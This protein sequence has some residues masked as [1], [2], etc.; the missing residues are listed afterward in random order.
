MAKIGEPEIKTQKRVIDLFKKEL[1]YIY[2]GDLSD[3]I[4]TNVKKDK[5]IA[6]LSSE[7]GGKYSERFANNVVDRLL[8]TTNNLQQGLYKANHDVYSILRYGLKIA[9]NI[10]ESI[11]TVYLIDW[12][13]AQNNEFG[14]AE[15]VTIKE[16]EKKRR[17]DLVFYINGIAIAVLELKK[18]TI[19]VSYGIR[20]NLSNQDESF[21]KPFFT[22][23]QLILAGNNSEGLRYGVIETIEKNYLEWKNEDFFIVS[24]PLD[25][26]SLDILEKCKTLRNKLDWQLYS[27]FYKNRLLDLIHNFIIFD[28]GRKKICRY[29]QFFAIK[30]AQMKLNKKEG[31]IIW[32]T[33][34]SGKTMVMVWLSKW[35]LE[36]NSNARVLIVTDREELDSQVESVY[37][38]VEENIYRTKSCSDLIDKL[39]K[40]DK[41]LMCTLIHKF[42]LRSNVESDENYIMRTIKNFIEELE[43]ALPTNFKA[44]GDF[45]VF[46]DECHRTQ[47]GLLHE[48]MKKIL[49]N[50]I[51]I[52]FTGT[53]LMKKDKKTSLEV[54]S[55]GFIH[56]YKYDKAVEDGVV[57]ELKYEAR[58]IDQIIT[59]PEKIEVYFEKKTSGLNDI[60]KA[61]L[62]SKWA[63][64]QTLFSSRN[65]LEILVDDI[66]YDFDTKD[67]LMTDRGNAI[68]VA[69]SIYTACRFYKIFQDRNFKKCAL[70][71]SF[72]S[73]VRTE[74][75]ESVEFEMINIYESMLKDTNKEVFE[76]E[77][78]RKFI[79]EPAQMKLLIVVDKLL[80]GFDAPPCTY[81]YIDKK[82]KD[83]GLFQ[84]ICRV[85]RLD[86]EK[87]FGYIVDYKLSFENLNEALITYTSEA[88]AEYDVEDIKGMIKDR[89]SEGK[90]HLDSILKDLEDLCSGVDHPYEDI[91]YERYF[92]GKDGVGGIDDENC[93]RIRE[94]FYRL[95]NRLIIA[96]SEIKNE[97]TEAGYTE[98]EKKNVEERASFFSELKIEIRN[99]SGDFIDLKGYES[100]M[101]RLIDSYI[102]S[103]DSKQIA[104][105]EDFTLLKFIEKKSEAL[106][107]ESK[108]TAAEIIERN[109]SSR[110]TEKMLINP[111]YYEKMSTLLDELVKERRKG[112]LT[113]QELIEKYRKTCEN[114]ENPE[115]DPRYPDSIRK[116]E[117]LR[118]LYD[119]YSENENN[120]IELDKLIKDNA[121]DNFRND[122][123]KANKLKKVMYDNIKTDDEDNKTEEV[124]RIY[125]IVV[126]LKEY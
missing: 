91:D 78:K 118:S 124:E 97:M 59:S 48:A 98:Q 92:I 116:N 23:N 73:N 14:I 122:E 54:F 71:T 45:V 33:Q 119:N 25:D 6:W 126:N 53:P 37:S 64:M 66:I 55:P 35:I 2:Y 123:L 115:N 28:S 90:K 110:I 103:E 99:S 93:I 24:Q 58:D 108:N 20:Q 1:N 3:K 7:K 101:R 96:F 4:N 15:E 11:K 65:R 88:F 105:F 62:K 106:K 40:S 47:S 95:V 57:L 75:P 102:R 49:P 21:N 125:K 50:S 63:N 9:E 19:S 83:H 36:N 76:K 39:E 94:K 114:I 61:K 112:V 41:R 86:K 12:Q 82:M 16:N 17:P 10:G 38:G 87:E 117:T 109:I 67:R 113:A 31:G 8:N 27:M 5:L 104:V 89:L 42:G 80:T 120:V 68:L 107:G 18:S 46:V 74:S 60:G 52:G 32:H 69:E 26:V 29:N 13:Y 22:T 85:N 34:G 121:Q 81:L 43:K 79:N 111:K 51:F 56:T 100:D 44:K 70:I 77:A 72:E 84:A 30:K